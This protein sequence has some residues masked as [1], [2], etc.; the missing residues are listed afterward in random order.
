M[1]V[2]F[3][4]FRGYDHAE[5]YGSGAFYDLNTVGHQA[6]FQRVCGHTSQSSA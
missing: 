6:R 2:Y 1:I 4:N 3:N 5:E